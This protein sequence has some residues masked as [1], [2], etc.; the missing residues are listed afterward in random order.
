MPFWVGP[1]QVWAKRPPLSPKD[2]KLWPCIPLPKI[3]SGA[4]KKRRAWR[5][6]TLYWGMPITRFPFSS[7]CY[8][9]HTAMRGFL[10]L[11][12]CDS[13]RPGIKSETI[14]VFRNWPQK[15]SHESEE[16]LRRAEAAQC[17]QGGDRVCDVLNRNRLVESRG[18]R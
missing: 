8:R 4:R 11:R 7:G 17:L 6:S 16:L 12:R 18:L 3:H 13:I 1:M 5:T 9:Y 10:L 15:R 2:K 14:L